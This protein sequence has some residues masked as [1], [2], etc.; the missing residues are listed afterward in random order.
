MDRFVLKLP[1]KGRGL[2]R[3][4]LAGHVLLPPPFCHL[5]SALS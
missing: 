1:W 3:F 5:W 2:P 4:I